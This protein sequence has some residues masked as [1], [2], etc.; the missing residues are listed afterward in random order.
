V[1]GTYSIAK[2]P[3][4][5]PSTAHLKR[6]HSLVHLSKTELFKVSWVW[7]QNNN[8][9][10]FHEALYMFY[11]KNTKQ[12]LVISISHWFMCPSIWSHY[13]FFLALTN[14]YLSWSECFAM[15]CF[16][17]TGSC[18]VGQADLE[19]TLFLVGVTDLCPCLTLHSYFLPSSL[20]QIII[21]QNPKF[22]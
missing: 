3:V 6:W 10:S 12:L 2:S 16:F 18:Y 8:N 7:E 20:S 19:F 4:D 17:K 22:T 1:A 15:F 9:F 13:Y 5:W 14:V 11:F 21:F